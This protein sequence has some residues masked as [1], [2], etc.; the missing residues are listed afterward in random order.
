[1]L[2][3]IATVKL[4]ALIGYA[5]LFF[6]LA[7]IQAVFRPFDALISKGSAIVGGLDAKL[8]IKAFNGITLGGLALILALCVFPLFLKRIDEKAYARGLW[9]G[10]IA[11][12]VFYLYNRLFSLAAKI[13]HVYFIVT[14]LG[15]IVATAIVVEGV[16]LAVKEE[17]ERSFRTDVTAS[18]TSGL[19]FGVLVKL[20]EFGLGLLTKAI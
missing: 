18:I 7:G 13:G 2:E 5:V 10:L 1:M 11:A 17:N 12:S 20:A 15:V 8:T 3:Q 19:L 9:R 4:L 16:S 6:V 14:M